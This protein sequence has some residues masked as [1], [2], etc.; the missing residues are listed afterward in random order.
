[1]YAAL[2][3]DNIKNFEVSAASIEAGPKAGPELCQTVLA[4][5]HSCYCQSPHEGIE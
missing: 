3:Q 1:M 4:G 2:F 5:E